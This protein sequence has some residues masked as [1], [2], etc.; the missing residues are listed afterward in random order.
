[1]YKVIFL[2]VVLYGREFLFDIF[3]LSPFDKVSDIHIAVVIL[4]W[5]VQ[6]LKSAL[7]KGSTSPEDEN[8]FSVQNVV[9]SSFWN[10]G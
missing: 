7:S 10:T 4:A 2:T 1:L 9:F 5:V 3:L 6:G 8:R